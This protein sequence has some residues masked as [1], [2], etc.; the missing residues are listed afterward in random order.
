MTHENRETLNRASGILK[1]LSV[2]ENLTETETSF[3]LAVS[4]MIDRVLEKEY[5]E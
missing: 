2:S 3:I 1:G 4:G 5:T